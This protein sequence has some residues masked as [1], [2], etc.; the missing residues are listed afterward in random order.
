MKKLFTLFLVLLAISSCTKKRN[1]QDPNT[2]NIA[3]F[4]RFSSIDPADSYD[5]VT[6]QIVYQVYETLYEYHYLKRPYTLQP[7]IA[8]GMPSISKNGTKYVS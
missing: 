3:L 4:G 1:R 2:L 7:L 8:D 5:T 6:A